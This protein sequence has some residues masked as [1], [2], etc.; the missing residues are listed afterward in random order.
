MISILSLI[1]LG[2]FLGMRHATDPDHVI[3]VS[4]IVTRQRT[5]RGGVLIGGLWGIGHTLTVLGVGALITLFGFVI[6]P[7]LGLTMEM[8]VGL[9]LVVLG[10]W[11][12]TGILQHI[13]DSVTGRRGQPGGGHAHPHRHGDYVHSHRHG[14][15][16]SSHGHREDQTPQA[17]LD[18]QLGDL[19]LYQ[20]VRPLVVGLLHGLAGSAAVA[21]LVLALIPNPW[22][23]IVYLVVF[24]IGTIA[25]MMLITLSI[26]APL[27]YASRRLT[28][29]DGHLRIAS[30]LVSLGFGLFVVYH[31]G[32]VSGLFAGRLPPMLE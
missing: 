31:I 3:A 21:L 28:R 15:G 26:A 6:P 24:G 25:G 4:T 10:L 14:H 9:M 16:P 18:R 12:L 20:V 30:G 22:W 8:A 27:S 32:F 13:R 23:A 1:S 2:F 29:I 5:L 17:W 7:R 19:G 11:N